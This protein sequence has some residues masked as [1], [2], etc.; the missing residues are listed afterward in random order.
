MIQLIWRV[1]CKYGHPICT[2]A[3]F[4]NSPCMLT[5]HSECKVVER[6]IFPYGTQYQL[7]WSNFGVGCFHH[8]AILAKKRQF[9]R[10][11]DFFLG[12][13]IYFNNTVL[14]IP[15]SCLYKVSKII[16]FGI[17]SVIWQKYP[18]MVCVTGRAAPKETDLCLVSSCYCV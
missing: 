4:F 16:S 6:Q 8:L 15:C 14:P 9:S 12:G 1:S 2:K 18:C 13:Q 11:G 7:D 5:L 17:Q 3:F 10:T